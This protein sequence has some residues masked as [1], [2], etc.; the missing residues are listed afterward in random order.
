MS[1][2]DEEEQYRINAFDWPTEFKDII[3]SGGFD[4]VIGNPPYVRQE[5]LG[6]FKDYFQKHYKIYHGVADLYSYFIERGVSL[7]KK[8][9]FFPTSWPINGC[10][11]ITAHHFGGG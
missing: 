4:I 5:T 1:L 8:V 7:I 11:L 9:V 3:Q 2:L 10:G 6:E